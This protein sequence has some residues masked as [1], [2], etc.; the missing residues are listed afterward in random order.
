MALL[1]LKLKRNVHYNVCT[2]FQYKVAKANHIDNITFSYLPLP[3]LWYLTY[4]YTQC[5]YIA[6]LTNFMTNE[7]SK[8]KNSVIFTDSF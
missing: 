1:V 2:A 7:I 6:L 5:F 3:Y 4:M 8:R